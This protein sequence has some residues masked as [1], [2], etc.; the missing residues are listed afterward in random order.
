[1][2]R[3]LIVIDILLIGA[4]AGMAW[5]L[6]E[7]W[8]GAEKRQNAV[9]KKKVIP[10][11]AP[12]LSP[13]PTVPPSTAA[14]YSDVAQKMLFSKDRN[15]V[16]VV[17]AAPPKPMPPLPV[18]YGVM[19]LGD[20]ATAFL[21]EKAG[22]ATKS[23]RVGDTIGE[24]KLLA[25][26]KEE[27]TLEWDGQPIKKRFDELAVKEVRPAAQPAANSAPA[28]RPAGSAITSVAPVKNGPGD[29]ITATTRK[30]VEGDTSAAGAVVDGYRKVVM[31]MP[32]GR[33]CRW[34]AVQ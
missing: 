29:P 14:A 8:R 28:Q 15:P 24:F 17:E 2:K 1:M 22:A 20:G 26:N 21:G 19:D 4:I 12:P 31:Q 3:K 16:V 33:S 5:Q 27:I 23:Y 25:L 34:D 6:R 11:P 30:C 13:L 32:M 18:A 7:Q 10:A 9:L